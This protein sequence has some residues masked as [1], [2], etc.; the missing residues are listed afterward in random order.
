MLKA[1]SNRIARAEVVIAASLAGAVTLLVL[2][3]IVS[4]AA[5]HAIYWVDELAIYCMVW[6]TF[7]T[8]SVLLKKRQCVAV[9]ILTDYFNVEIRYWL[10]LFS[11]L[12][13]LFFALFLFW[14][15]WRWYDPF[16][17]Y[18]SEFDLQAFQGETFNF[19][20]AENTNTLGL[21]KFWIW[22]ALPLFAFSLS[23]HALSNLLENLRPTPVLAGETL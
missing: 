23:L 3:N 21:K 1:V 17:L 22:L 18:Q 8:T 2:L 5:G 9:T 12:M 16:T 10:A 7:F 20:Y 4:R 19:M 11:D 13:V 15:C 6:M 14:L